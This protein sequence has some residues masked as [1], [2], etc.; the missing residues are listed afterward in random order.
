[1]IGF[2]IAPPD[3][4]R[5]LR[6]IDPAADLIYLGE[7][8]WQLGRYKPENS[9][10]REKSARRSVGAYL[11]TPETPARNRQIAFFRHVAAT[12][13]RPMGSPFE[14]NEPETAGIPEAMERWLWTYR[15]RR[16]QAWKE[17][18]EAATDA[19]QKRL[20]AYTQDKIE[21]EGRSIFKHVTAPTLYPTL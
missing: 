6:E 16:D 7:G 14:V 21:S 2:R 13:F 18:L 20:Q 10:V 8:R 4:V 12:G 15:H 3:L 17:R 5:R 9:R 11:Q 1:M 19:E